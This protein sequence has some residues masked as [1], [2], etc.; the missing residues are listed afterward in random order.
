MDRT[1][2][3]RHVMQANKSKDT[4]PE[5]AVRAA[6]REA[7]LKELSAETMTVEEMTEELCRLKSKI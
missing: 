5:L 1:L 6:L 4:G 7:G 2:A 3:T